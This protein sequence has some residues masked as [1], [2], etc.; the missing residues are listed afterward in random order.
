MI[1]MRSG[2]IITQNNNTKQKVI[3]EFSVQ[4][5]GNVSLKFSLYSEPLFSARQGCL[6]E[7]SRQSLHKA[8]RENK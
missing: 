6:G 1:Y 3:L 2:V 7:F 8:S 4:T 5:E